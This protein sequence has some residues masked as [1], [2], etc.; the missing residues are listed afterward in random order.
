ML[1]KS[2]NRLSKYGFLTMSASLGRAVLK[3]D[4]CGD[5]IPVME[6]LW[7]LSR[8]AIQHYTGIDPI[9]EPGRIHDAFKGIAEVFE[10]DLLFGAGLPDNN[11]QV[12]DWDNGEKLKHLPDGTP[13]VQWGI[14]CTGIQ[15]DGRHFLHVPKPASV[16][17][18]LDFDPFH[19]FP[20]T[21][22]QYRT[23][24]VNAY[25]Q[26]RENCG[27]TCYPIPHHYTTLYHCALAIFGFELWCEVGMA[28]ERRLSRLLD[29]FAELSWRITT[30]WSQV[31]G[32]DGFILHDDLVTTA[33][34]VFAPAW[35]RR[36]IFSRYAEIFA[37]LV[38]KEIPIVFTSDGN[39]T[40]FVDDIFAAGA[41]GLNMEYLVDLEP[42]VRD[43]PDKVLIG[44][45]NS[46]ILANGP[47]PAIEREVTRCIE[48]G[49]RARRFVINV[50]G[51]LTHT[52]PLDHLDYYLN[53]RRRL[54]HGIR[55]TTCCA[56]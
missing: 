20:K 36:H 37:P 34:P 28:D 46:A 30:A 48:V 27:D 52:M 56:S 49:R 25:A 24:F 32:L 13:I 7:G 18:A 45:I 9:A 53:L 5:R 21:V 1:E 41:D 12:F 3:R 40:E 43:Y 26:M 14:F 38:K 51:Q 44:N 31:D 8:Q 55:R 39:C 35:Y 33:G 19:Y 16:D 42:L 47:L 54:A 50:G 11:S 29:R 15:E 22:E 2:F 10:V 4:Y 6:H 17:E 23:E